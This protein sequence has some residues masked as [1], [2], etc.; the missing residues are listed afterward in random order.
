MFEGP[1]TGCFG[2]DSCLEGAFAGQ[3]NRENC[4]IEFIWVLRQIQQA[5]RETNE[6]ET[7]PA[8]ASKA[9]VPFQR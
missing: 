5:R 6:D 4:V 7:T 3:L 2:I 9:D 8:Y 1:A